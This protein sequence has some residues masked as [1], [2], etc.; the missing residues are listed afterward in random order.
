ML[1]EESTQFAIAFLAPYSIDSFVIARTT[2]LKT[3]IYTN[4]SRRTRLNNEDYT[5]HAYSTRIF[6]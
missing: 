6:W 3:E 4:M 2:R 1:K 5:P